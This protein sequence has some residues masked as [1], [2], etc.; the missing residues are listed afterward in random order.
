MRL[1]CWKGFTP[2]RRSPNGWTKSARTSQGS[3][4]NGE[5]SAV[6][7]EG[8]RAVIALVEKTYHVKFGPEETQAWGVLLQELSD[9][10]GR[11]AAVLACRKSVKPPVPAAI[12]AYADEVA[13]RGVDA[14]AM[15]TAPSP[16]MT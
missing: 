1:G 9:A 11:L 4:Q 6:T 15:L 12:L 16:P 2:T 3:F 8:L 5:A 10:R 14:A 13:A 7:T